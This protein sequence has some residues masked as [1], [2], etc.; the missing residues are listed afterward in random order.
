[1]TPE[2]V[3]VGPASGAATLD[4]QLARD[5]LK[6][7]AVSY[8]YAPG[9]GRTPVQG[10][11]ARNSF[12]GNSL[13]KGGESSRAASDGSPVPS[14]RCVNEATLPEDNGQAWPKGGGRCSLSP[15]ER[16]GVRGNEPSHRP[17]CK[18]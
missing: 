5:C 14:G 6:A 15:R 7:L 16:A 9:D 8:V 12:W 13:P 11:K 4:G 17:H 18:K 2:P 3:G 10:F 1:M